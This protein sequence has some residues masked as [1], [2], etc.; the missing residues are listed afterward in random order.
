MWT[1]QGI[2]H[3]YQDEISL[4]EKRALIE[5]LG[6]KYVSVFHLGGNAWFTEWLEP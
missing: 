6:I 4:N 2:S 5:S 1:Y 3:T